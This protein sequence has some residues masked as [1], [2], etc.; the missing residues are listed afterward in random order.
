M[1]IIHLVCTFPPYQGGMG[2]SVKEMVERLALTDPSCDITVV[3]PRYGLREVAPVSTLYSVRRCS[4]WLRCGNAAVINGL[5]QIWQSADIVHL[6]YPFYGTDALVWY[7]K[8]RHPHT[9]LVIHYHMDP[10][11]D[12]WK[13][14]IFKIWQKLFLKQLLTQAEAITCASLD[15]WRHSSAGRIDGLSD[16]L[17]IIPFTVDTNRFQP[18]SKD[19]TL[20]ETYGLMSE[21]PIIL[22]VGGLDKAHYFK[23]VPVLLQALARLK[24]KLGKNYCRGIIVGEGNLRDKYYKMAQALGLDQDIVFIGKVEQNKLPAIYNL[25]DLFVLPSINSC[26]AFGLV[27]LEAMASGLPCLASNLPGVRE[28]IDPPRNGLLV[29]PNNADDLANKIS[30]L[31]ADDLKLKEMAQ[32]SRDRAVKYFASSTPSPLAPI[33]HQL[34]E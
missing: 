10:Q 7:F 1:K 28:V 16:K 33:Y 2:N 19:Q 14:R 17:F 3:C 8:K 13:G 34:T 25:A 22:M 5:K 6:H 27:L 26:E 4:S 23:G 18:R 9:K 31:L 21:V 20:L 12:G 11:A 29:E 24:A 32:A 30:Q 15:Y